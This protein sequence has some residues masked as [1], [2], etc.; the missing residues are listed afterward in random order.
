MM[1][2]GWVGMFLGVILLAVLIVLIVMLIGQ[3]WRGSPP[4]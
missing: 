4:R 1:S 3:T 2:L